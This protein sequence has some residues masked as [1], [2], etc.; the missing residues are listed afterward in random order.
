MFI[1]VER[2]AYFAIL[3]LLV[4]RGLIPPESKGQPLAD[5]EAA[6]ACVP[7]GFRP[8]LNLLKE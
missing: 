7:E 1:C 4:D 2:K 8:L 6:E 3:S 5:V